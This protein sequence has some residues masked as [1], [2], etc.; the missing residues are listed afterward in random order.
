[1]LRTGCLLA[2]QRDFVVT[3]RRSGLPY[4]RP[5][6]TAL[7]GHYAGRTLTGK[8]I[9]AFRTH[10]TTASDAHPASYSLPEAIGYR[11]PHSGNTLRRSPG[12]GGPL[13]FPPPLSERS[14]PPTPGSPSRLHFQDLHRFHGLRLF[15]TSSALPGPT[16]LRAGAL[17]TLQ[18]SLDVTDRSVAHP[19]KRDARR[20]ASTPPVSRRHR[21]P[22]TGPPDSYPDR[23]YTGKR[24]RA[25]ESAINHLHDQPPTVWTHRKNR[26]AA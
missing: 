21:Q 22:A 15:P 2:P 17:T 10:T 14:A 1:M 26:L 13:Q 25:Y 7:L 8:F 12:R 11:A 4:R 9:T 19:A 18:A 23:T 24:R 3:L 6:A 5:P 16:R 20:W